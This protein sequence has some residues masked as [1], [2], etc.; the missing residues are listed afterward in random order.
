MAHSVAP[1]MSSQQQLRVVPSNKMPADP[2][3]SLWAPNAEAGPGR[4]DP[5]RKLVIYTS[6]IMLNYLCGYGSTDN[7]VRNPS[8]CSAERVFLDKPGGEGT[9]PAKQISS[10][11]IQDI[12]LGELT[13]PEETIE[14]SIPKGEGL[15]DLEAIKEEDSLPIQHRKIKTMCY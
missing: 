8:V 2:L 5:R 15:E 12:T 9:P 7:G 11:K 1:A 3:K 13:I 14:D 6:L 4:R 10:P